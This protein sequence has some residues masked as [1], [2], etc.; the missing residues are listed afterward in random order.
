MVSIFPMKII[1]LI[2]LVLLPVLGYAQPTLQFESETH[3]FGEVRQGAQ[4]EHAFEF[5]NSGKED[6]IISRLVPS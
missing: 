4:L 5:S 2:S 6:L 1:I 3:D